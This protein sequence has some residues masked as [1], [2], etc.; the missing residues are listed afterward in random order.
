MIKTCLFYR[1]TV[2]PKDAV[3]GD[4]VYKAD[5]GQTLLYDGQAWQNLGTFDDEPVEKPTKITYPS[6]CK[7][8][9]A[10]LKSHVCEYCGTHY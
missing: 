5:T 10:V 3:F 4:V 2:V 7:N 1:G 8:C 6:N 9:G